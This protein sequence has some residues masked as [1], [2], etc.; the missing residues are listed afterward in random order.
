MWTVNRRD[1]G[2]TLIELLVVIAIIA[3]LAGMLLPALAKA[4][5]KAMETSCR[6]NLRQ[7]GLAFQQYLVE[8]N[9]VFPGAASKGSYDPMEE[10]WIYWNTH[11]T[12]IPGSMRDPKN[13]P[14]AKHIGN[15][16]TNLFRCPSDKDVRKRDEEQAKSPNSQNRYLYSYVLL[17]Y[18][19][20]ATSSGNH[21][22]SSLYGKGVPPLHFKASSIRSPSDKMMVIE[23]K[24][25]SGAAASPDDG[26]WVPLDNKIADRHNKKGAVVF[27][28][29][30]VDSVDQK[31]ADTRQHYDP[32]R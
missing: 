30:H 23:E 12:R 17:S 1:L 10:D 32:T 19:E 7:I 27:P 29:N 6:S 5:G 15:F 8:N 31:Y 4:K 24:S 13:S 3:I 18:V 2:F 11:D 20:S 26:R 28:D 21:G 14:I 25:A 22:M 9:D 16:N